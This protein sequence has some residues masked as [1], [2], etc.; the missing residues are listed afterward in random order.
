MLPK[1]HYEAP[2]TPKHIILHYS[3][4]KTCWD[5]FILSL[6][7]YTAIFV[8]YHVAFTVDMSSRSGWLYA[9]S[10]VVG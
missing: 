4:F 5:W 2:Q 8:P 9:D 10:V 7:I 6:I 1:Y 3:T